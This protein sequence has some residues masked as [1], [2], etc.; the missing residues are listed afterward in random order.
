MPSES[1]M[2]PGR[3]RDRYRQPS[4]AAAARSP[5]R[6]AAAGRRLPAPDTPRGARPGRLRARVR[7][8]TCWPPLSAWA[9]IW[10]PLCRSTVAAWSA[11]PPTSVVRWSSVSRSLLRPCSLSS[12]ALSCAVDAA[13]SS[14]DFAWSTSPSVAVS[15]VVVDIERSFCRWKLKRLLPTPTRRQTFSSPASSR[16]VVHGRK[17]MVEISNQ[18]CSADTGGERRPRRRV[19]LHS[20][21]LN[22]R[23][24]SYV[25]EVRTGGTRVAILCPRNV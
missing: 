10:E 9:S 16:S 17:G 23:R 18:P 7:W 3:R 13:S 15:C 6:R 21:L 2:R 24:G 8:A 5:P 1:A 25:G 22:P 12:T 20:S 19:H 14:P 4:T 11:C